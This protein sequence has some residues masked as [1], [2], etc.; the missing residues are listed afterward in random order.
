MTTPSTATSTA[1]STTSSH[2]PAAVAHPRS[3]RRADP[4]RC[5]IWSRHVG[6]ARLGSAGSAASTPGTDATMFLIG[7]VTRTFTAALV[8]ALRDDGLVDLDA[9]VGS[10]SRSRRT[11]DSPCGAC[12]RT[13]RACS[14]NRRASQADPAGPDVEGLLRDLPAAEQV[15]PPAFAFTTP[16]SPMPCSPGPGRRGGSARGPGPRSCGTAC[17]S[18]S[19]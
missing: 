18:R 9:P 4:R 11:A 17:S 6:S 5:P 3:E 14:V 10:T 16:T 19:A 15:L 2:P 13:P 7:S 8:M 1:P 12:C